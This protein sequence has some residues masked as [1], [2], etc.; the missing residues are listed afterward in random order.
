MIALID[1]DGT[2]ADCSHRLK[3][4]NPT[5]VQKGKGSTMN[6]VPQDGWKPDWDAFFAACDKDTPIEPV[7]DLVRALNDQYHIVW[8]T[9]RPHTTSEATIKWLHENNLPE[10]RPLYMRTAGDHRQDYIVKRELYENMI[11]PNIGEATLAIEDRDQVVE[12]W[13]SLGIL[14]LQPCK[15]TY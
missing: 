4:I 15:G 14:T 1:I 5:L 2:I 8:V 6:F 3:F 11:K 13:R 12:M 7:C 10:H 9:G